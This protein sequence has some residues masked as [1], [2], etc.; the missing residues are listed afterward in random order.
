[1]K[2]LITLLTAITFTTVL[3]GQTVQNVAPP[4]NPLATVYESYFAL[5][6]ALVQSDEKTAQSAAAALSENIAGVP[7][8]KLGDNHSIWMDYQPK[9]ATDA[10]NIRKSNID[11]QRKLFVSLSKN[12]YEVMKA[13]KYEKSVYYFHCPMYNK[14]N[15]GANWLSLEKEVKNPYYGSKML[16]CGSLTETI[17]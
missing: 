5:K 6:D 4:V 1:M 2:K 13:V 9:L 15:G 12:M 17:K 7:M 10:G 11:R 14:K 3:Y 16:T 8:D